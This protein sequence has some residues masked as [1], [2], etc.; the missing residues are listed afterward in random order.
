MAS[1]IARQQ[2][3]DQFT[4]HFG[5]PPQVLVRAAGRVNLIGE[6]TDYND[7]FVLPAAIDRHIYFL[8]RRRAGAKVRAYAAEFDELATFP[9]QQ[10]RPDKPH[11]WSV[12]LIGVL[13]LLQ[14]RGVALDG[15]D[16]L[17]AGN[18]PRAAGLS[19]SAA[20]EVGMASLVQALYPF[21]MQE[22]ELIKLVQQAEHQFAGTKCGIM[23]MFVCRLGR[24]DHALFL[25]CRSLDYRLVPLQLRES[26]L[27]ICD[28]KKKRGLASS[29]YNERR[30]QCEEGVRLIRQWLPE[31]RALRDVTV[32]QF[33]EL[34]GRLPEVVRRRCEHVVRENA[35]VL[36]A[37]RA[38]EGGDLSHFGRL[39][40]QSHESLR[41]LY[42][43]SCPELDTLVESALAV[44]GTAGARLTGAGFGGCT[45]NLVRTDAVEAFRE[46]VGSD[47]VRRF[48]REPGI[49]VCR[50][51]D[52]VQVEW[53]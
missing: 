4:L 43:V 42:E 22:L 27:V 52:G 23:D 6:H 11:H 28:S 12:Y 50:A 31:V 36:Y 51:D 44:D 15:F 45:V 1:S 10:E 2:L 26:A 38:L 33:A 41:D 18:L 16:V 46:R 48:G 39:M 20:L 30:A 8:A 53:L 24:R 37:V 9:V 14:A 47:Y 49:L 32:E 5:A 21:R 29:A 35:R 25:D 17:I 34:S 19:S 7:G 13:Q 3:L 40:V